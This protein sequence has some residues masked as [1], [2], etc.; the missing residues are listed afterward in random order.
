MDRTPVT[1]ALSTAKLL[2][3]AHGISSYLAHHSRPV[4]ART[5]ES[6]DSGFR[7]EYVLDPSRSP[8]QDNPGCSIYVSYIASKTGQRT[9]EEGAVVLDHH[10][11]ISVRA[12]TDDMTIKRL[13]EREAIISHLTMLCEMLEVTLPPVVMVV[14]MTP[15]QLKEKT[16]TDMEQTTGAMIHEALGRDAFKG[17]RKG[18]SPRTFHNSSNFASGSYRYTHVRRRNSRGHAVESAKYVIGVYG[19]EL[20]TVRRTE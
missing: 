6:T 11:N 20:I 15:D 13:K 12:S 2:V 3:A 1:S 17:L 7:L 8:W 18:G 14:I 16:Q 4:A 19:G 10:L 9:T 5:V